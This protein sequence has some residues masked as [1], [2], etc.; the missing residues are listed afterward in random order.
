VVAAPLALLLAL[1]AAMLWEGGAPVSPLRHLFLVPALWAALT[2]GAGAGGFV[3]LMAGLLQAPLVLPAIERV[4][5][6]GGA[7]DGL[8]S[9]VT[10]ATLGVVA[11]HVRDQARAG[12]RRLDAL[13]E[14]QQRLASDAPLA[15]RLDAVVGVIRQCLGANAVGLVVGSRDGAP[16]VA[17]APRGA[18]L[19]PDSTAAWSLAS[20][21]AVRSR[22][23]AGDP[24]FALADV[25][26]PSPIRAV[27]LPLDPGGGITAVL[28]VEWRGEVPESTAAAAAEMAL[29]LGLGIENARLTLRQRRFAA[30]LEEKV[31]AATQRLRHIDRAKSEFISVVSHEL[32]TPLT[33]LEGFSELLLARAVPPE[34]AARFLGH[35]HAESRRLGRIVTELLDLSRIDVGVAPILKPERVDLVVHV[36]RQLELFAGVHAGHRFRWMPEGAL[37]TVQADPDALDR[38]LQ[39]LLSNAVKYSPRGGEVKVSARAMEGGLVELAVEDQGVGIAAEAL[40][41]I[42]D[43]YVRIA[44]PETTT[45]RGLGLGLSLVRALVE[46][47]GGRVEASSELGKGSCFRLLLPVKRAYFP[48]ILAI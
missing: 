2:A 22:D 25:S 19:A 8:V 4:G 11:G 38:M 41:R 1:T 36:E 29:H 23:L 31:A 24:R 15:S 28:A 48:D 10:P 3:G 5:L 35:I 26:S 47:H 21:E 42:F 34:R 7:L 40:P 6:T 20:G 45:V 13:L 30:D 14:I 16:A 44:N 27:V 17:S 43:K 32:R 18:A 37:P 12:A 46:A 33:A 9:L 39:N